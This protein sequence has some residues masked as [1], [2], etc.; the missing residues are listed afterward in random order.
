MRKINLT[1]TQYVTIE[2]ELVSVIERSISTI[3]DFAI[4]YLG[5]YLLLLLLNLIF[6]TFLFSNYMYFI[7]P[8]SFLYHLLFEYYNNG[9]SIGKKILKIRV[10][11]TNGE[12]PGIFD[13]IIRTSFRIIDITFTI[14]GLALFTVS[15]TEKGQ[16][17]GDFIA[18]TTVVKLI[19]FDKFTLESVLSM[20][21]LKNYTPKYP[22]VT[23]FNESE[24]L[25]IKETMERYSMFPNE[26]NIKAI[27]SIVKK[28]EQNLNVISTQNKIEFLNT[29]IKDYVSLTR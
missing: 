23:F 24:I 6:S 10:V 25:L 18:D 3:I 28:I 5:T 4:I 2:Y 15:S 20:E 11:K 16:R 12:K 14:G 19:N 27:N 29:I 8:I 26:F 9:Q 21:K 22:N 13:F 7:V 17:L 1:T